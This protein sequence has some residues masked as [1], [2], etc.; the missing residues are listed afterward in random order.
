MD[1]RNL[2][3]AKSGKGKIGKKV[4]EGGLK[5]HSLHCIFIQGAL[6][7]GLP[8]AAGKGHCHHSPTSWR[9]NRETPIPSSSAGLWTPSLFPPA[10]PQHGPHGR[11]SAMSLLSDTPAP[12]DV[13]HSAS[14]VSSLTVPDIWIPFPSHMTK[15][16]IHSRTHLLH[17]PQ[18]TRGHL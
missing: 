14:P 10:L 5:S 4:Q 18:P 7:V 9:R 13:P 12:T 11:D 17:V 1:G 6:T 15:R 8:D 2:K 3:N 16:K